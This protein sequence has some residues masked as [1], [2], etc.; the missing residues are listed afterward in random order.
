MLHFA[1]EEDWAKMKSNGET[2]RQKSKRL[3]QSFEDVLSSALMYLLFT[4]MPGESYRIVDDSGLVCCVHVE[5][6]ER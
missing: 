1:L 5:S 3:R 2:A 4:R 6:L